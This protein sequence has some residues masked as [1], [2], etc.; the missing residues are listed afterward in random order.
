MKLGPSIA[1][2]N[3]LSYTTAGHFLA[4]KFH[5]SEYS[6]SEKVK[7]LN[8]KMTTKVHLSRIFTITIEILVTADRLIYVMKSCNY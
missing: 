5:I 1:T 4:L 3:L 6:V 8:K 7:V 2:Y